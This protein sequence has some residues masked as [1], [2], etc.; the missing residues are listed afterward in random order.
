MNIQMRM[1]RKITVTK[2]L[3]SKARKLKTLLILFPLWLFLLL[4]LLRGFRY[5]QPLPSL[6]LRLRLLTASLEV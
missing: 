3:P 5:L 1:K 2:R 4:L 6:G